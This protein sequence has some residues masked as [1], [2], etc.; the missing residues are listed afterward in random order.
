[1][2]IALSSDD[3]PVEPEV[4]VHSV[5]RK[6]SE[7]SK[8]LT[9]PP[10]NV[11]NWMIYAALA[12]LVI[13]LMVDGFLGHRPQRPA[14]P[15]YSEATEVRSTVVEISDSLQIVVSWE[16]TLADS[17]GRPD[18]ILVKVVTENHRDSLI[19]VQPS[20]QLA[21][22]LYLRPPKP[23]KRVKGTSCAAAEH[24]GQPLEESCTPWQYVRPRGIAQATGGEP[25]EE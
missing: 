21:D 4:R 25:F 8:P 6:R 5:R 18:S 19:S 23:G 13:A 11:R 3:I 2:L 14:L 22:T 1:M 12:L 17:G 7:P 10:P 24:P 16:L 20:D 9:P 15:S